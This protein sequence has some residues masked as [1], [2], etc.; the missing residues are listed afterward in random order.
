M[1]QLTVRDGRHFQGDVCIAADGNRSALRR[2]LLPS[3]RTQFAGVVWSVR[4]VVWRRDSNQPRR[5]LSRR[6][7]SATVHVRRRRRRAVQI[8]RSLTPSRTQPDKMPELVDRSFGFVFGDNGSSVYLAPGDAWPCCRSRICV[9]SHTQ[10]AAPPDGDGGVTWAL[11]YVADDEAA[12]VADFNQA[13]GIL[14]AS[15]DRVR[16][17]FGQPIVSLVEYVDT[18]HQSVARAAQST[19]AERRRS[20]P[21]CVLIAP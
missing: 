12:A 5:A 7:C 13:E 14:K 3:E 17:D 20:R 10:C 1:L 2:V 19:R 4:L 21:A 6:R 8:P 11:S 18:E 16:R 9:R 15:V